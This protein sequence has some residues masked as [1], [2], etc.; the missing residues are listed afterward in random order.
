MLWKNEPCL[1]TWPYLKI[2]F[3]IFVSP[4]QIVGWFLFFLF[5]DVIKKKKK[6]TYLKNY[7][8]NVNFVFILKLLLRMTVI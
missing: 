7:F 3:D 6:E 8:W 1:L 4:Y 2:G 5:Y